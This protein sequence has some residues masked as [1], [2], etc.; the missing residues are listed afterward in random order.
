MGS[1]PL[2]SRAV[3]TVWR[4]APKRAYSGAV[5]WGAGLEIPGWLRPTL[6][7]RFARLYGIDISEAE[8]ALADYRTVDEFFTRQLRPGARQVDPDLDAVVAPSDGTVIESGRVTEGHLL[9]V[10]GVLFE[11]DDLLGDTELASRLEGG[12]YLTTYLSP[13]DYHRVHSPIAGAVVGWRYMPGKLYPVGAKSVAR[14]PGLFIS[15]ERLV[16]IIDGGRAGLCA[17]VMVA[18]VGV[19]HITAAYDDT[20]A[21]HQRSFKPGKTSQMHYDVPR[22]VAKG[23][24][25]GTFHLGSTT[26]AVF[27]SPRV[28][29]GEL[30]SGA[31][32]RMGEPIGRVQ[33]VSPDRMGAGATTETL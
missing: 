4:V 10:K 25:I 30:V 13:R 8:R 24:E 3:R 19:G 7:T 32:T 9:Q 23:A 11:L 2:S 29:L 20:I 18:A 16:T 31:A 27:E 12:G 22:P 14:E 15:N 6:L 21:T 26:I 17:L 28:M 33:A 5:G 1:L